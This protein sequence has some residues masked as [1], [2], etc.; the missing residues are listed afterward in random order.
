MIAD[1]E[2]RCD[3]CGEV[4]SHYSGE[5]PRGDSMD[6]LKK[7]VSRYVYSREADPIAVVLILE[8]LART[9]IRS[10]EESWEHW[11][12]FE[13]FM[14]CDTTERKKGRHDHG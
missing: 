9:T 10:A 3:M 2:T 12:R 8:L 4:H 13:S 5:T 1:N 11:L 7:R 6:A 14:K